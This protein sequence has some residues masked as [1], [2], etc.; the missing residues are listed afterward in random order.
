M[1]LRRK[2]AKVDAKLSINRKNV[3]EVLGGEDYTQTCVGFRYYKDGLTPWYAPAA[4]SAFGDCYKATYG[5]SLSGLN[6]AAVVAPADDV[7]L[8][9]GEIDDV[10]KNMS[11]IG[12]AHMSAVPVRYRNTNA[13]FVILGKKLFVVNKSSMSLYRGE[14]PINTY[15]S[16]G[17]CNRIFAVG[18]EDECKLYWSPPDPDFFSAWDG[19]NGSG[20][21]SLGAEQG[22]IVGLEHMGSNLVV[23]RKR[24]VTV[25][26]VLGDIRHLSVER[27][28]EIELPNA[29]K[30]G[31]AALNGK[32]Y[33]ATEQGLCVFDGEKVTDL[34]KPFS[35]NGITAIT[36]AFGFDNKIYVAQKDG[37][38][39]RCYEYD[40][41]TDCIVQFAD[42]L[43][44]L[45]H[46]DRNLL[47]VKKDSMFYYLEKGIS[48]P[49]RKWQSKPLDFGYKG[50]KLLRSV[51]VECSA[52]A[53]VSVTCGEKTKSFTGAGTFY[54]G[55]SGKE[56]VFTAK[57]YGKIT[58]ISCE[59]E[60]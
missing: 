8:F 24:G 47:C 23:V 14:L 38:V 55:E 45:T 29:Y 15:L 17:H 2:P 21:L 27:V 57:G 49:N 39:N 44:M 9:S 20:Y 4:G 40:P 50:K 46:T 58:R 28:S 60:A 43:R 1:K 3:F 16:I 25:L 56:F 31:T 7:A 11:N 35:L 51:T 59:W 18:T 37:E 13:Y 41:E 10:Y 26:K 5:V 42:N 54:F 53:S 12:N 36:A 48:D 30:F 52:G 6:Y 19:T 34:R 33:I 32:I 22:G